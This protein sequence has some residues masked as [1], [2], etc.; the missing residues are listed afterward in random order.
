MSDH[1]NPC[2]FELS[3]ARGALDGAEA[4]YSGLFDWQVADSG[5]EGMEYRLASAGG[6][7]VAGL[8][9]M[10]GDCGDAAACWMIYFSVTNADATAARAVELGGKLFRA[11][12]DIPG[13]GRFAMLIDPQGA[14]FGI[15]QPLPMDE[16]QGGAFDQKK[17][18]HGNWVE[19]MS[20]DPEAGFAFYAD[21][22]GWTAAEAM[23]MGEMGKYQLFM[24]GDTTIGG[25]MGV[26]EGQDSSWLPYFGVDSVETTIARIAE[27]GGNLQYGPMEVPGPAHIAGATDPQGAWFAVVG[28]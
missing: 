2:W 25:M 3:T 19:L 23:D 21:L 13:T 10:P 14:T 24:Q 16:P 12:D 5:M 20:K 28:P 18:G 7:M 1:G 17:A 4:F 8:M 15:L 26:S 27:T 11:P 9:E 22:F 6:D